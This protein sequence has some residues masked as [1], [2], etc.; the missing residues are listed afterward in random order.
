MSQGENYYMS[1]RNIW[2]RKG[3]RGRM[4][5]LFRGSSDQDDCSARNL[6]AGGDVLRPANYNG[7]TF[8]ALIKPQA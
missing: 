5:S 6:D 1:D 3:K 7:G 8:Q 4:G 2:A